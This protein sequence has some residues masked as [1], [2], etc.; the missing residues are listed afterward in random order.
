MSPFSHYGRHALATGANT[1]TGRAIALSLAGRGA[2]H[3]RPAARL[4]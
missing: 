2:R 1:G 4:R 3:L